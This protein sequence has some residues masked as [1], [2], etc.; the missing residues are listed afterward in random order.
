MDELAQLKKDMLK[1][2]TQA[3]TVADSATAYQITYDLGGLPT[4][5]NIMYVWDIYVEAVKNR[6]NAIFTA[7]PVANYMF[8]IA[9]GAKYPFIQR[10]W[11]ILDVSDPTH[12]SIPLFYQNPSYM[13]IHGSNAITITSNVPIRIKSAS[14]RQIQIY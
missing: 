2:K 14:R 4:A 5:D 10:T 6:E 11:P 1:L 13:E 12:F 3:K 8:S 7:T 9:G